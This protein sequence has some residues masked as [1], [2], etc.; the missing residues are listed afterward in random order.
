ME[1]W[2]GFASGIREGDS[3]CLDGKMFSVGGLER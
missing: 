2:M 1:S 3:A